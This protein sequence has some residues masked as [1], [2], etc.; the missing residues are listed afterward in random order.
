MMCLLP[1]TGLAVVFIEVGQDVHIINGGL[2]DAINEGVRRATRTATRKSAV[3]DPVLDRRTQ[4]TTR[5]R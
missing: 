3:F 2:E 1:D 5:P 4:G